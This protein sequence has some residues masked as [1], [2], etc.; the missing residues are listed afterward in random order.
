MSY[1]R[2]IIENTPE[3]VQLIEKYGFRMVSGRLLY[4]VAKIY[5]M[6]FINS[7]LDYCNY[8]SNCIRYVVGP[9]QK[10][11]DMLYFSDCHQKETWLQ[12][13]ASTGVFIPF[14]IERRVSIF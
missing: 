5:I 14:N 13:V 6:T 10:A 9:F 2:V 3:N 7:K 8:L 12:I 4:P 11:P 1:C